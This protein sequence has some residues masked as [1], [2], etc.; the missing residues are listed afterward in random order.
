MSLSSKSSK[1]RSTF[2]SASLREQL[3]FTRVIAITSIF[4]LLWASN[5]IIMAIASSTPGSVSMIIFFLPVAD[6]IVNVGLEPKQGLE[7]KLCCVRSIQTSYTSHGMNNIK[8]QPLH[9][10]MK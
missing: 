2:L 6:D 5:A 9:S 3:P 7:L 10:H 1:T 4:S 8:Q